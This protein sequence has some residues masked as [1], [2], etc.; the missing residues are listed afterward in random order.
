MNKSQNTL[1]NPTS[2]PLR[3]KQGRKWNVRRNNSGV[4]R[5]RFIITI[6]SLHRIRLFTQKTSANRNRI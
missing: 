4:N 1:Y 6:C 2:L 3:Q 5:H